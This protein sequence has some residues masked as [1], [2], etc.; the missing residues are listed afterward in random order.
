[1]VLDGPI[2]SLVFQA[3]VDEAPVPELK[4]GDI[5]VMGNLSR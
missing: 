5:V 3:H 4:P 2:N 1:M